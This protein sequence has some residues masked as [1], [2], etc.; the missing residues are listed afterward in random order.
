MIHLGLGSS[1]PVFEVCKIQLCFS[2]MK[3]PDCAVSNEE[4]DRYCSHCG[5]YLSVAPGPAHRSLLQLSVAEF[6]ATLA[7]G[8]PLISEN[9]SSLWTEASEMSRLGARRGVGILQAF[10]EEEAAKALILFDAVRCP[11]LSEKRFPSS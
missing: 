10:A 2:D 5:T 11:H 1:Y 6:L 4:G 9:A 7:S 8:L 3:C